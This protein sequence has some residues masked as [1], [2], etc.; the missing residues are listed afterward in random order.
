[1]STHSNKSDSI[2]KE[3]DKPLE[4]GPGTISPESA[5]LT[6]LLKIAESTSQRKPDLLD[7]F[8]VDDK[9]LSSREAEGKLLASLDAK[10][11]L[12]HRIIAYNIGMAKCIGSKLLQFAKPILLYQ[13]P[14]L[15]LVATTNRLVES[16]VGQTKRVLQSSKATNNVLMHTLVMLHGISPADS[17][18]ALK[19]AAELESKGVDLYRLARYAYHKFSKA[20][21]KVQQDAL[22]VI[23]AQRQDVIAKDI[24]ARLESCIRQ[25]I[26]WSQPK[27]PTKAQLIAIVE[28]KKIVTPAERRENKD[29]LLNLVMEDVEDEEIKM[30]FRKLTELQAEVKECKVEAKVRAKME[31]MSTTAYPMLDNKPAVNPATAPGPLITTQQAGAVGFVAPAL[32]APDAFLLGTVIDELLT[33]EEL[34]DLRLMDLENTGG[35]ETKCVVL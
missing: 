21:D 10:M 11:S 29:F 27:L 5:E 15:K 17:A 19:N 8:V 12:N 31:A 25:A 32:L 22:V 28:T 26:S 1:M 35:P 24:N 9:V 18:Q 20:Q 16:D 34:E 14:D 3:L 6:N 2:T 30:E 13:K 33:A 4:T 7:I 23:E